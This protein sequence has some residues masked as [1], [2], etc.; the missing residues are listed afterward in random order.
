[1]VG[2]VVF[3][4]VGVALVIAA[5]GKEELV[6]EVASAGIAVVEVVV[7]VTLVMGVVGVVVLTIVWFLAA[8]GVVT[9]LA[10]VE[11]VA[12]E[13]VV[14]RVA[15][16]DMVVVEEVMSWVVVGVLVVVVVVVGVVAES[17]ASM[18]GESSQK[19]S[20]VVFTGVVSGGFGSDP[21]PWLSSQCFRAKA[22]LSA[23]D[24]GLL[25]GFVFFVGAL[26]CH[27]H[28]LTHSR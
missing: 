26:G 4:V 16:V 18:V 12:L 8:G 19:N 9:V 27:Q 22:C 25:L 23:L 17:L 15:V 10:V 2:V 6:A 21:L 1:M 28:W 7:A 3:V 24:Q 11:E 20:A 13:V 14:S 5:A